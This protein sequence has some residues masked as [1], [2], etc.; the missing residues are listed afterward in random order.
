V[1][2]SYPEYV[3]ADPNYVGLLPDELS[4]EEAAPSCAQALRYIRRER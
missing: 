1:Q 3:L 2:G 4:L